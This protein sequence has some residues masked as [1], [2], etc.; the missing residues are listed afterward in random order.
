MRVT[1]R[2][3]TRSARLYD[4]AFH[5]L[6]QAAQAKEIA[7]R[8]QIPLRFLERILQDLRKAGIVEARRGPRGGYALAKPPADVSLARVLDAVR[9]PLEQMFG[10][11]RPTTTQ[12][13]TTSRRP[14][15]PTCARVWS[16]CSS[17][18]RCKT[19]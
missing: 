12:A 11:E 16:T 7:D 5:R 14:C 13:T 19:S 18:R 2:A 17:T 10:F 6:G 9:G 8:Q 1:T 3:A 4:L 15:G